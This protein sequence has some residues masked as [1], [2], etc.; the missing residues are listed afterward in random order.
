MSSKT[1]QKDELRL[2]VYGHVR[3]ESLVLIDKVD[4]RFV[5]GIEKYLS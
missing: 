1:W 5:Y 2:H 4:R 3:R